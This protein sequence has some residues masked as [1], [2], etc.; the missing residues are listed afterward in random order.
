[1]PSSTLATTQRS[2]KSSALS[3]KPSSRARGG[4]ERDVLQVDAELGKRE[5]DGRDDPHIAQDGG[6]RMLQAGL[7]PGAR[8]HPRRKPALERPGDDEADDQN[9]QRAENP[10]EREIDVADL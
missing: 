9:K 7:E 5:R 6:D 3:P 10:R 1:M 8:Q 2:S 4:G